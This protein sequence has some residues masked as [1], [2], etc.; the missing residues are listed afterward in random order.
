METPINTNGNHK[1]KTEYQGSKSAVMLSGDWGG[2]TAKLT[3]K[4][5]AGDFKDFTGGV[6]ALDEQYEITHGAARPYVTVSGVNTNG[7]TALTLVSVAL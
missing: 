7:T 6:L 4:T 2:A 1:L 5:E 3:Y